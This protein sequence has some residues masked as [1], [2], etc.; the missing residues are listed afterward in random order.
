MEKALISIA[1][2]AVLFV[3]LWLT[4]VLSWVSLPSPLPCYN[5]TE[6]IVEAPVADTTVVETQQAAP[7]EPAV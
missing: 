1:A 4:N 6:Q 5:Q 7:V 3:A 2:V